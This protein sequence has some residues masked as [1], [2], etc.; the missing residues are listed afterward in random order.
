MDCGAAYMMSTL[1]FSTVGLLSL[2]SSAVFA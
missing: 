1:G 2:S